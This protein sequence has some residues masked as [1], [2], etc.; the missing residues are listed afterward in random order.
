[1]SGSG[2]IVGYHRGGIARLFI[3]WNQATGEWRGAGAS[4][5]GEKSR[6]CFNSRKDGEKF[7]SE[8]VTV[9]MDRRDGYKRLFKNMEVTIVT[10]WK[11]EWKT[12]LHSTF[13]LENFQVVP[14]SKLDNTKDGVS[15]GQVGFVLL[16]DNSGRDP[17][18]NLGEISKL[19][20]S[21]WGN[22]SHRFGPLEWRNTNSQ[23]RHWREECC[24][25]LSGEYQHRRRWEKK[26]EKKGPEEKKEKFSV[27]GV[28]GE[29]FQKN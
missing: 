18:R 23:E 10:V 21:I 12:G 6:D 27:T 9:R 7:W 26:T 17:A 25:R 3:W 24:S 22:R 15:F 19:V 4:C 28:K 2:V 29:D 16:W 5:W 1:M 13:R 11:Q 14:F 8:I 20:V